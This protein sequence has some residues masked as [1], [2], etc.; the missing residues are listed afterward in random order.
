M[1]T[2]SPEERALAVRA[3]NRFYTRHIGLLHKSYLDSPFSLS[4]MRVLY[5]LA[6]RNAPA[7]AEI[8]KDLNLDT[9]YLSRML[10]KFEKNGYI[11]RTPST[12]DAR[13]S[14]LSLTRRGHAA[15][16]PYETKATTEV[17][18]ILDRLSLE[19]QERLVEAMQVIQKLLGGLGV[20]T[21]TSSGHAT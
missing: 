19:D 3:F 2:M 8:S 15:F 5:E 7:A 18:A 20:D 4:E 17:A 6:H 21:T 11:R 10:L 13:Q 12:K 1:A 16:E 14:D 9:G